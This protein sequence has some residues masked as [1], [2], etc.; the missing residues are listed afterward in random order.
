MLMSGAR[1][2]LSLFQATMNDAWNQKVD[3]DGTDVRTELNRERR[4]RRRAR[5]LGFILNKRRGFSAYYGPNYWL[6]DG[7]NGNPVLHDNGDPR[8]RATLDGVERYLQTWMKSTTN[9]IG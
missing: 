7:Y 2:L 6:L 3:D 4:L 8:H 9:Q 5:R 1:N